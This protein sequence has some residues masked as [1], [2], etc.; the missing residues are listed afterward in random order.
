[1][2]PESKGDMR[3][4][5]VIF[6]SHIQAPPVAQVV[7]GLTKANSSTRQREAAARAAG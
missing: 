7:G 3:D 1:M 2:V 6:P 5:G 4:G